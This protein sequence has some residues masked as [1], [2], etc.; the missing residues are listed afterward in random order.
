MAS[1]IPGELSPQNERPSQSVDTRTVRGRRQL[2]F[3]SLDEVVAD[4]EQLASSPTTRMLGNWPLGQLLA[5]L[6]MAMNR[7]IDGISFQAPWYLR[8]FGRLVKRRVLKRGLTPGFKLPKDRE[9]GAYPRVTSSQEALTIFR[10]AVARMRNEKATAIHPFFGRLTHEEW[11]QFH[12]RHAELH[13]SF[14]V[15]S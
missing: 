9:A 13:L 11:T 7:S 10:Q 12:L 15:L 14:A 3:T 6:A 2:H 4:A 5:H 8:L 1:T